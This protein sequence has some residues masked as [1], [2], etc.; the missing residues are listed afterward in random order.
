MFI[1]YPKNIN[2][3]TCEHMISAHH[4][5]S[6]KDENIFFSD[7]KWYHDISI[8]D[9][10]MVIYKSLYDDTI[11]YMRPMEM[12]QSLVD[13]EKHPKINQKWRFELIR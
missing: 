2:A 1:S 8:S 13:K 7:G 11:P 10:P 12:F 6:N 5:E 3:D 9:K 4:T